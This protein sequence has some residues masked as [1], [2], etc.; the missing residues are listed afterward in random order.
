MSISAIMKSLLERGFYEKR[1]KI[2]FHR[3][4]LV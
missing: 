1:E 2:D 3:L 4:A